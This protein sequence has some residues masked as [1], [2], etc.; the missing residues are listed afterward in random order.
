[1]GD[2]AMRWRE[3]FLLTAFACV[4]NGCAQSKNPGDLITGSIGS[5]MPAMGQSASHERL[6]DSLYR[7]MADDRRF[8]DRIDQ[9]N[10]LLLKAAETT[11][12]ADA[13]HF[14]LVKSGLDTS[15]LPI[16][17]SAP[18]SRNGAYIRVLTLEPGTGVPVGAASAAEIIHFFGPKYTAGKA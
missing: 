10:Y 16:S 12:Q 2:R 11:P 9:E 5:L 15:T 13:T 3:A 8:T 17:T 18:G 6:T 7:V 4:A 14:Y 1:P